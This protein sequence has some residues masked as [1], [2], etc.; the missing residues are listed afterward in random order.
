M[1]KTKICY[2]D[3]LSILNLK[4]E[5]F[6]FGNPKCSNLELNIFEQINISKLMD[7]DEPK[8]EIL[9]VPEMHRCVIC[10]TSIS[11]KN[12]EFCRISCCR[13]LYHFECIEGCIKYSDSTECPLCRKKIKYVQYLYNGIINKIYKVKNKSLSIISHKHHF[14]A[15]YHSNDKYQ[16]NTV[17]I[18]DAEDFDDEKGEIVRTPRKP[19]LG[20][21]DSKLSVGSPT[22]SD[23]TDCSISIPPTRHSAPSSPSMSHFVLNDNSV[24]NRNNNNNN[25]TVSNTCTSEKVSDFQTNHDKTAGEDD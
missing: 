22:N 5:R 1:G 10:L 13:H 7:V 3:I 4:P 6:S 14:N 12:D 25:N 15:Y 20:W 24:S 18:E 16:G 2:K 17:N 11:Y 8:L 9:K 23:C 19:C 21:N